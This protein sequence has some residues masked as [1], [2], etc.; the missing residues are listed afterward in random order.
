MT[1]VDLWND[2]PASSRECAEDC[3]CGHGSEEPGR[4]SGNP[5]AFRSLRIRDIRVQTEQDATFRLEW[6]G[7]EVPPPRSGQ[8]FQVSLPR[9]GE[10]PLSVSDAGRDFLEMTIRRVGRVTE[11]IFA[12]RPGDALFLRGPYGNGFDHRDFRGRHLVVAAGGTGL[13]PVKGLISHFASR[14]G[15]VTRLDVLAGFK[16]PG[17]VLFREELEVWKKG[18][19]VRVT[20][21]R[22][23]TD[24]TG[25]VGVITTL[26]PELA[27]PDPENLTVVVVG[28]PLMMKFT[29]LAFLDR[30]VPLGRIRVSLERRMSCGIG[31]CGHCKIMDRYV[32]LDGP[33][34]GAAEALALED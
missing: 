26:V 4:G 10:A 3:R 25:P 27:F 19:A 31:K 23:T 34:F 5:Y 1:H 18:A 16:T 21:D 33:V 32:C 6:P 8:F 22:G 12:C 14:A 20:V 13:A 15:E 24:W 9:I 29:V 17:D 30:G 11:G 28:P 7:D 2:S